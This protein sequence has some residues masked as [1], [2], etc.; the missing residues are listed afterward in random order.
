MDILRRKWLLRCVNY[1]LVM[2]LIGA[3]IIGG[4]VYTVIAD[5]KL[6]IS[7]KEIERQALEL[8]TSNLEKESFVLS[9]D[10]ETYF[11]FTAQDSQV[12]SIAELVASGKLR[13]EGNGY[14]VTEDIALPALEKNSCQDF[15]CIQFEKTFPKIPSPIW[16]GLLGTEDFRFLEHRGVDPLAIARAIIVD[17]IAMK[18]VQGGS[19]LTQQLMKNLFLSNERKLSRKLKE[20]IYAL[21]IE[22][23]MSKEQIVT[24]YL[25]EMFWGSHQNLRIKGFHAASLAYFRKS[26]DKLDEFEATILISLLKGPN[27]Y[28]PTKGTD[29]IQSRAKAVFKRLQGLNLVSSDDKILWSQAR[30]QNYAKEYIGWNKERNLFQYYLLSKNT[31]VFLEPFEKLVLFGSY[32]KNIKQIKS[33]LN[34]NADFATKV[35]IGRQDCEGYDCDGVFSFYSKI[36]REKRRSMT[37]EFHQVGSLFKPIVYDTFIDL[38]RA[39]DEMISTKPITLNLKSGRWTPKDYSKAKVEEISLKEA[40]QK[41]KNIPLIR[42]AS[43]VGF[44]KLEEKLTPQIPRLK[45]PLSEFPAQL[46]GALELS[47]SEVFRS[48]RNF[49]RYKCEQ[50]EKT[51][52]AFEESLLFYMSVA[53]ETTISRVVK[54]PLS[55]ALVFGK[56]GTSNNGLDNWYFAFDGRQ[57][58]VFWFG[59]ESDRD[60]T[61]LRISGASSSFRMFQ[62]FINHRGKQVSE[63]YCQANG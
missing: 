57:L 4:Y 29:R 30:W 51:D 10:L 42:V 38:G 2:S 24:L 49:L 62:D 63:V 1:G 22:N 44:E 28:N 15:Q 32:L 53:S 37:E 47:M 33:R 11:L 21:Y 25:N 23:V 18:F 16:K 45:T 60:K 3:I 5:L 7:Q 43:E 6:K 40:L 12:T 52:L 61:N 39:Y 27:Y 58:Y 19:T 26:P 41:S 59:V 14:R 9:G 50:I 46:L 8:S 35:L 34:S 20:M 54:P 56:T 13:K 48:Y 31:D 55:N 17:V 36:E